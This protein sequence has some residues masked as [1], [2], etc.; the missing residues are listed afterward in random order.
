MKFWQTTAVAPQRPKGAGLGAGIDIGT[1]SAS[2]RTGS[3]PDPRGRLVI[4]TLAVLAVARI[5]LATTPGYP[6]DL[7]TYKLWSL[8][9][10]LHGVQTVYDDRAGAGDLQW[11]PG[12]YDYPPLYAYIL[13]PIGAIYG[14][15]HPGVARGLEGSRVLGFLVKIPPLVFDIL[16]AALIGAIASRFG[17]WKGSRSRL[18]WGAACLY[19]MQPAVLF[20]SGYWGQ[21]DVIHVFFVLLALILILVRRPEWGW[22]AA[23]LGCLMK[24]LAAPFLPLLALATLLRS[25]PRRLGTGVA[26]ALATGIVVFLPFIVT[27]RGPAVLQRVLFDV[28][29]MPYT[30]VNSH[31]LWWLLGPWRSSQDPWIGPVNKTIVG[32]TLFGIAYVFILWRLWK[33]ERGRPAAPPGPEQTDL[34][35]EDHWFIAAAGVAFSFFFFSTHMHENHLFGAIPFLILLAHRGRGWTALALLVGLV[36][37]INMANHDLILGNILFA[38]DVP[39]AL[40][41]PGTAWQMPRTMYAIATA[42]SIA[43]TLLFAL[44]AWAS[45]RALRR[46][47]T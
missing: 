37:F 17:S 13:A 40:V 6:P 39:S 11:R 21:P 46:E 27:G 2:A 9:A 36:S 42:N 7:N 38:T 14:R 22:V 5:W 32:L 15:I 19:L 34:A 43:T 4:A 45:I 29:V 47:G 26:A 35:G 16:I 18:G 8:Q 3:A 44:F 12:N 23:A 1:A 10:G 20:D 33:I 24:P 25:G 31:N 30:S 28:D 41:I